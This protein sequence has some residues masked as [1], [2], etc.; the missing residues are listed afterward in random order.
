VRPRVRL[1]RL[2]REDA[3]FRRYWSAHTISLFGDQ[4]SLLA[5]PLV[6]VLALDANAVQMGYLTAAGWVPYLVFSLHAGAWV[7]RRGRR[8]ATMIEADVGRALVLVSV[9]LAYAADALTLPHLYLVALAVGTFS[10]VFG[11]ADSSLFVS[12]VPRERFLE[13]NSLMHGSRAFSFVAGP[14]LTGFLV[15][16]LTA[17]SRSS[18]TRSRSSARQ[19][20]CGVSR[21]PRRRRTKR[22]AASSSG[23]AGSTVP[24]S[25]AIRC[26]RRRRSTSSTSSSSRSSCST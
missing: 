25:F 3:V 2:L 21:R 10:V 17:R 16:V 22:A 24:A 6:G 7:D 1:P 26:S 14:S 19:P 15:Q 20:S 13:A 8:R 18:S 11:V 12:I 5:I 23:S 9:P 4:V